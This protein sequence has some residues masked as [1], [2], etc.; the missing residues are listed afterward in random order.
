MQ[1]SFEFNAEHFQ[2]GGET[3]RKGEALQGD[4]SNGELGGLNL[5]NNGRI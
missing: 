1:A 2:S 3:F 5:T 4:A